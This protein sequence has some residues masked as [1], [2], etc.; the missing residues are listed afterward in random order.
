VRNKEKTLYTDDIKVRENRFSHPEDEEY[1]VSFLASPIIPT[2]TEGPPLGTIIITSNAEKRFS[3]EHKV[4]V[5]TQA[6]IISTYLTERE[7]NMEKNG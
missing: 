3:Q 5:E 4:L 2:T 6:L 7:Q 1:Y